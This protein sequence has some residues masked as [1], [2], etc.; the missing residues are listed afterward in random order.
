MGVIRGVLLV[1]V[2]C[3]FFISVFAAG[4]TFTLATSLKYD[5]VKAQLT[6]TLE[7]ILESTIKLHEKFDDVY[8]LMELYC[9]SNAEYIFEHEGYTFKIPC[10]V[11]VEGYDAVISHAIGNVLEDVYYTEYDCSFLNCFNEGQLPLFLVSEK[12]RGFWSSKF[13][14]LLIASAV[15]AGLMFLL[16]EKKTNMPIIAGSLLIVAS[17]PFMKL[18]DIMLNFGGEF[19]G[20]LRI[21]FTTSF[22]VFIRMIILGIIVLALGIIL[23]IFGIGFKISELISKFKKAPVTTQTK[24]KKQVQQVSKISKKPVLKKAKNLKSA[25]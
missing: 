16:A 14:F 1:F 8:P 11:L 17:L 7:E 3:L 25:L 12:A 9:Q 22:K 18:S 10:D 5:N 6:A 24:P 2:C 4:L 20:L 15:L 21:F 23:K 13:Y 19:A